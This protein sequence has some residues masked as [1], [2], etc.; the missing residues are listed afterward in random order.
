M[1]D[2]KVERNDDDG[3]V[4]IIAD[5]SSGATQ[6]SIDVLELAKH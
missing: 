6:F 4:R 3:D 1:L 2:P 5:A